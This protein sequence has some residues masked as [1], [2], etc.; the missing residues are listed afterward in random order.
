MPQP[1][2]NTVRFD[3]YIL[4]VLYDY[5]ISRMSNVIVVCPYVFNVVLLSEKFLDQ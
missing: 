1:V 3:F 5:R 4:T 2:Y